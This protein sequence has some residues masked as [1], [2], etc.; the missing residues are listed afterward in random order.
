[1]PQSLDAEVIVVGGGPAGASTACALAREGVDVLVLDRAKFPR[2][3][4]CA[5]YLSP[6]AS[7]ILA[8]M[9]VL[10][11]ID[12]TNPAH[13]AGMRVRAPNGLVAE[14]RFASTH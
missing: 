5:E 8:D 6:Q 12:G 9:T 7:R 2:D 4:I 3:K 10:E 13:L 1:V 11:E 14:G